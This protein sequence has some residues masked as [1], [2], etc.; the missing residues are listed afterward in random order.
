MRKSS[1]G[2]IFEHFYEIESHDVNVITPEVIEFETA[3]KT[4][5]KDFP[6]SGIW[7]VISQPS[8]TI[9]SELREA[10]SKKDLT[11]NCIPLVSHELLITFL[12]AG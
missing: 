9:I 10:I 8:S 4:K 12:S 2:S 11:Q 7:I 3:L 5:I 6:S 1:I